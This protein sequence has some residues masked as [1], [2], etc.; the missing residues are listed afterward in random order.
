MLQNNINRV[1]RELSIWEN[2]VFYPE[3]RFKK[4][5]TADLDLLKSLIK[6]SK[7]S[8][9][10][11]SSET[12]ACVYKIGRFLVENNVSNQYIC[13]QDGEVFESYIDVNYKY[14]YSFRELID[15]L[16]NA[17]KKDQITK[18]WLIIPELNCKW[19]KKMAL[20]FINKLKLLDVYG[21]VFYSNKDYPDTLAQIIC[22][23]SYTS[24]HQFPNPVYSTKNRRK[25]IPKDDY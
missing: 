12:E 18:K 10:I 3:E 17:L 7:E 21:V 1:E 20:Y 22:E 11:I 14:D 19:D 9:I 23:D 2:R 4:D 6:Q 13:F 24:I 16:I 5:T 8:M 15:E 25:T